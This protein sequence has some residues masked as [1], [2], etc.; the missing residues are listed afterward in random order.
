M[1][2]RTRSSSSCRIKDLIGKPE[3]L[4]QA[5]LPTKKSALQ[6][7]LK[8]RLD[9]VRDARNIPI[10][11][12]AKATG[13]RVREI[14]LKI[15]QRMETAIISQQE[16]TR[17]LV[18]LYQQ[19]DAAAWGGKTMRQGRSR[20]RS[21]SSSRRKGRKTENDEFINNLD[22]LFDLSICHCQI[23]SCRELEC[24]TN[25]HQQVHITCTCP[26]NVKIPV[27]ELPFIFD[28]R[29]KTGL[30]G[31]MQMGALDKKETARQTRA[32]LRNVASST[33]QRA[34]MQE[35]KE[36]PSNVEKPAIESRADEEEHDGGQQDDGYDEQPSCS[37]HQN[38][39]HFPRTVLAG[40][41]H[42]VSQKALA[43]IL[44]SFSIDMGLATR[45]DPSLLVDTSKVRR[46]VE[47]QMTRVNAE[48]EQ[49]LRSGVIDAIQMDSK[50]DLTK[51][52]LTLD[53]GSQVIRE[54]EEDHMTITDSS[55]RY[56]THFTPQ[57]EAGM[58][59]AQ[60]I[61]KKIAGFLEECGVTDTLKMV[62]A[63]ST[64]TNTGCNNGILVN[65]ERFLGKRLV[66]SVCL[67]HT[68]EL[69]LRHLIQKLDGPTTSGNGF[70]GEVGKLLSVTQE[71]PENPGFEP[72]SV[73][74]PLVELPED[75]VADLSHDQLFG[76]RML[77][78]L[79]AGAIHQSLRRM[80]IGP[81]SHSRWLTTA[82]RWEFL[83]HTFI[84]ISSVICVPSNPFLP[85]CYPSSTVLRKIHFAA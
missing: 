28:Q 69:P 66:W 57:K 16:I 29:A 38:R 23:Q 58:K 40:M 15:N 39:R 84:P 56:M 82:N 14:W 13:E 59:P 32:H 24:P 53:D 22:R 35:A 8:L 21:V 7:M 62:G 72:L 68:N 83:S 65:L 11:E 36:G 9:D 43:D 77:Q 74:E 55:G 6:H 4:P 75:V 60:S 52:L 63:D 20:S 42:G 51:A 48:A 46:E 54:V 33:A 76:L 34:A 3:K 5:D 47:R 19:A 80:A 25:C 73:G 49:W 71:L 10:T 67:L 50:I 37:T 70:S 12:L 44:S 31:K 26:K 17:K 78:G 18:K 45:E 79:E 1:A 30:C 27:L 81:V 2:K 41:R 85:S 64:N 61:A